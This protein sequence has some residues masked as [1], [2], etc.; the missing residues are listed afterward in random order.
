[1]DTNKQFIELSE[2]AE[3]I[4]TMEDMSGLRLEYEQWYS[5]I[6]N[7]VS[8]HLPDRMAELSCTRR[9]RR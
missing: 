6:E 8:A 9:M 7:L 2:Q 5:R 3:R 4:A 1:M